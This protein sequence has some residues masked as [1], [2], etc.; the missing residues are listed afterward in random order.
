MTYPGKKVCLFL[1]THTLTGNNVE[2]FDLFYA[3][4]T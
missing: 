1:L 3:V 2:S 4:A